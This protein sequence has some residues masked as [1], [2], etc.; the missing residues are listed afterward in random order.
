MKDITELYRGSSTDRTLTQVAQDLVRRDFSNYRG[1]KGTPNEALML[2]SRENRPDSAP[3]LIAIA[4]ARYPQ[5]LSDMI[6]VNHDEAFI[7]C[8]SKWT[9][10]R[11]QSHN[12]V[13]TRRG[14]EKKSH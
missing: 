4:A 5:E 14:T 7:T 8:R 1:W 3:E 10:C 11:P 12:R 2:F 9:S 13:N 6:H